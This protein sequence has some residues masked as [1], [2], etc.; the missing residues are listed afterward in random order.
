MIA[1][2]V[3]PAQQVEAQDG[4][5]PQDSGDVTVQA[6]SKANKARPSTT[7]PSG[8]AAI[9]AGL[10][11]VT[12]AKNLLITQNDVRNRNFGGVTA[13]G[14]PVRSRGARLATLT[15]SIG[16]G[17]FAQAFCRLVTPDHEDQEVCGGEISPRWVDFMNARTNFDITGCH[18]DSRTYNGTHGGR[19]DRGGGMRVEANPYEAYRIYTS[20]PS[21]GTPP[22][23]FYI[24]QFNEYRD[25]GGGWHTGLTDPGGAINELR[26]LNWQNAK[27]VADGWDTAEDKHEYF[28]GKVDEVFD[29]FSDHIYTISSNLDKLDWETAAYAELL[30]FAHNDH[31][32]ATEQA[33]RLLGRKVNALDAKATINE[34][35]KRRVNGAGGVAPESGL[36]K[37]V[38]GDTAPLSYGFA[39]KPNGVLGRLTALESATAFEGTD[40]PVLHSDAQ[41]AD[42]VNNAATD[43]RLEAKIDANT[44]YAGNVSGRVSNLERGNLGTRPANLSGTAWESVNQ[45]DGNH[46]TLSLAVGSTSAWGQDAGRPN[47]VV[48]NIDALW[49]AASPTATWDE[50]R[51]AAIET[52]LGTS[53]ADGFEEVYSETLWG[54]IG[55]LDAIISEEFYSGSG[56]GSD[57]DQTKG[58]VGE[59]ERRVMAAEARAETAETAAQELRT[60]LDELKALVTTLT[61]A[62]NTG[63]VEESNDLVEED[64]DDSA[65]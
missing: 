33:G 12:D 56:I 65:G 19:W 54:A 44:T 36:W 39:I 22:S 26:L 35:T 1:A 51:V 48:G 46:A 23:V 43:G 2:T 7:L 29:Y 17:A 45:L 8:E 28:K 62:D 38:Y 60:E 41:W 58:R 4:G 63:P 37:I 13:S 52:T 15:G 34:Q 42:V 21:S 61:T 30:M 14:A 40:R 5:P 31:V 10:P 47:T 55:D 3:G 27:C 24:N 25:Y 9:A 64:G 20:R 6:A 59:L 11:T 32:R 50:A 49:A 57:L 53:P 18:V 16:L